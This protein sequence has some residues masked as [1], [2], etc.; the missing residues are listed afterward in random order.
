MGLFIDIEALSESQ[1]DMALGLIYK[2]I[3]DHDGEDI[4]LPLQSKFVARLAQLFTDRGLDRI[5]AFR[6]DLVAWSEGQRHQPGIER[7]AQPPGIMER[8]SSGELELVRLYLEHLPPAQWTLAD[9]MMLVDWL[10]QKHLPPDVMRAEADWLATRSSLM[11]RV[12]ASMDKVTAAQADQIITALPLTAAAAAEMLP[13]TPVQRVALD[14]AAERA[15]ENVRELTNSVRHRMRTTIAEWFNERA[16]AVQPTGST[17]ALQT[18]LRDQFAQLNRDWRRIAVTETVEAQNQGYIASVPRGTHV[19]RVERYDGACAF[20]RRIDG[21]VLEVVD[22]AAANKDGRTQ[23]WPGKT[24]VGRSAAPRKRLGSLLIE[25]EPHELWWP[26]AGTQHPNCRG[27]WVPSIKK[28]AVDIDMAKWLVSIL[29]NKDERNDQ[30][31]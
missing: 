11:G 1:S 8:W 9:H 6:K 22:P 23:V 13:H 17:P 12:Q 30:G 2:A 10:V 15:A 3:H 29:E 28:A 25:R 21:L 26:A 7:V 16:T 27:R 20:C 18:R 24:N 5:E 19:K 31:A 4:W 14:Y